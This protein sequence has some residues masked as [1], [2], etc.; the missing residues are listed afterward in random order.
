M[1]VSSAGSDLL[2]IRD[3]GAAAAAGWHPSGLPARIIYATLATLF[4]S[5]MFVGLIGYWLVP[6]PANDFFAFDSFSRFIRHYRPS[7]IYD[8]GLLRAFQNLPAHKLFAFMYPP[9]MLLLL[10]PL[11]WLPYAL[12]YVLWIA[13]G[14]AASVATI[15]VRHGGWPL[16]LLLAVAPSTLWTA[17][18]GQS[19]LLLAALILGGLLLSTRRP[20][21]AG[22]LLGMATYKPQLGILV[23]V[24]LVAAGQWRTATAALV[25]FIA[26]V[27]V[28]SLAFGVEIW[29]AWL[30]HL[31]SIIGVRTDHAADWAPLLA[32]IASDLA[33]LGA[34]RSIADLGQAAASF[35][36]MIFVWRCF[37]QREAIRP[38][39]VNRLKVAALGASTFLATPFAFIYD[40]PLFTVALLLFVDERRRAGETFHAAE[41]LLIVAG[42]L[43]PCAFLIDG[44]HSCGSLIVLLVLFAIVR[45]L[46]VLSS[47][48]SNGGAVAEPSSSDLVMA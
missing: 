25:T 12:G 35:A 21:V 18:C 4:A 23:P 28:T 43:D 36:S 48:P 37:R 30:T 45:R 17:L 14:V 24:A 20:V 40:L 10:W 1:S 8:Q 7:L 46:R 5:L 34:N 13:I 44:M 42:L 9:S 32:T 41:V 38:A 29:F 31:N 6:H 27:V 22:L 16:G 19:T 47:R 11:A 2:S 33:T 15:G 26:I 3:P 39:A